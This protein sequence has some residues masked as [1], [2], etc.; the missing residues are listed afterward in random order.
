MSGALDLA[1]MF[2]S[3]MSCIFHVIDVDRTSSAFLTYDATVSFMSIEEKCTPS[4]SQSNLA[5]LNVC[6]ELLIVF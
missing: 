3:A 1:C 2:C 5:L 6:S 4:L